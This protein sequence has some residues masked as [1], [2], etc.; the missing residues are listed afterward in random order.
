MSNE[1]KYDGVPV[2]QTNSEYD[3]VAA[4]MKQR[5]EHLARRLRFMRIVVR[6]LDVGFGFSTS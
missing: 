1:I 2:T 3:E 4:R 6:I 5:D